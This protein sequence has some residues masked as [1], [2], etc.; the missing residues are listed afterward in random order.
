VKVA[1]A[2]VAKELKCSQTKVWNAWTGFDPWG[3]ELRQ[4]KY[5]Y[6]AMCDAAYE[7]RCEV[8]LKSLQ[9]EYGNKLEFTD[10]EIEARAQELDEDSRCYP[11]D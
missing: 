7:Y 11:D 1:V 10:K 8:A 4:E 5:A 6:D 9:E 3:Y 2:A